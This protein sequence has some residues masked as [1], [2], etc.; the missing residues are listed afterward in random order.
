[1]RLMSLAL[2]YERMRE[3]DRVEEPV[4]MPCKAV[5]FSLVYGVWGIERGALEDY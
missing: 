4:L 1:M 3:R 5:L 2:G